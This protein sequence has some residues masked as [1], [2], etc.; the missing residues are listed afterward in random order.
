MSLHIEKAHDMQQRN[1]FQNQVVNKG[2]NIMFKKISS[3]AIA[4]VMI[5][6][7]C[8][9]AFAGIDRGRC[10]ADQFGVLRGKINTDGGTYE[11]TVTYNDERATLYAGAEIQNRDGKTLREDSKT[12]T[13]KKASGRLGWPSSGYAM[14]GAHYIEDYS[15]YT[16]TQQ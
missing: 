14:Y 10:D 5:L 7:M 3:I 11:S 13:S 4:V 15:F 2:G 16:Y 6:T 1:A 9:T 12:S 8:V